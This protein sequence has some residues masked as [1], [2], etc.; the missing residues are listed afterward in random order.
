MTQVE[1]KLIGAAAAGFLGCSIGLWLDPKAA[2]ASYL[3]VWFAVSAM[4]VGALGVL[5]MTYL[6]R[7]RWTRDLHGPLSTTALSTPVLALLFIPIAAG[8]AWI[9]PWVSDVAGLPAFKAAYLTPWFFVLRA[10][11]YFTIWSLL[12]AWAAGAYG[13]ERAMTRAASAGLIVWALTVSWAG[14]DW[15][16]SVE[17][18]FHSSIYGLLTLSFTLLA[19]FAFG[20]VALFTTK[21]SHQLSNASYAALLLATLLL[22]AYLHAMQYLII[23]TGNIPDEVI[24]YLTRLDGG[25]RYALWGL[26]IGQF[27]LPFFALLSARVRES[28][29]ALL[30]LAAFTLAFRVVEAV[31]LVVPPL[32]GAGV[33]LLLDLPATV[34]AL[35]ASWMIGWRWVPALRARWSDRAAAAG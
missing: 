29:K 11:L 6:V 21:G 13:D 5:L 35:G 20:L 24:W 4:P 18:H 12:A 19:G 28:T 9:Y 30:L 3:A 7:G 8:A 10:V 34:L 31:V 16:E 15:L 32:H 2:L 14:I 27:G 25:W 23:W 26:F 17:P 22:W 1:R 33:A